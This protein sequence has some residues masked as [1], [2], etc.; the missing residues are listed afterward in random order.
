MADLHGYF[1]P[2]SPQDDNEGRRSYWGPMLDVSLIST[3][4]ALL[5]TR[6]L[7]D[8]GANNC[9]MD[10]A[11]SEALGYAVAGKISSHTA[12]GDVN[13]DAVVGGFLVPP[14]QFVNQHAFQLQNF[15]AV[16]FKCIIG[17]PFLQRFYIRFS[18]GSNLVQLSDLT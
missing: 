12:G 1:H 9:M 11:T 17:W 7:L 8:S 3:K 15:S 5:K 2:F 6:A 18:S 13:Q 16:N 10:R 4:G 14:F